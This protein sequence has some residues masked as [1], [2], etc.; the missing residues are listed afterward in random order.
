MFFLYL[1]IT[2]FINSITKG[3][4]I[5]VKLNGKKI[6]NKDLETELKKISNS[7][8]EER[9]QYYRNVNKSSVKTGFLVDQL[10][11]AKEELLR[12]SMQNEV[13]IEA[14]TWR[15]I[16]KLLHKS[17]F[18]NDKFNDLDL[19]ERKAKKFSSLDQI[20]IGI[21]NIDYDLIKENALKN[22][23]IKISN[24]SITENSNS[25]ESA[26]NSKNIRIASPLVRTCNSLNATFCLP[27]DLY[28]TNNEKT[29][30][31]KIDFG[32][33][34]GER[35][36]KLGEVIPIS[37]SSQGE[38]YIKISLIEGENQV[39]I[40]WSSFTVFDFNDSKSVSKSASNSFPYPNYIH[41]LSDGSRA[42][43]EYGC[44][45]NYKI[46]K[47]FVFV[48]GLN[49]TPSNECPESNI[50]YG[51]FGW[52]VFRSG[53]DIPCATDP[54]RISFLPDLIEKLKSDGFD[55]I[56]L[57]FK[58]GAGSIESNA[59]NLI[60][61][62]NWVNNQ[63][64]INNSKNKL[65]V[66]G[67]SM[68]GVVSRY[69][70]SKMEQT[71]QN[72]NT[73]LYITMD[74]P[75]NGANI[76]LG[77]QFLLDFFS[78]FDDITDEEPELMVA[79]NKLKKPAP[80]QLLLYHFQG[81]AARTSLTASPY[82]NFPTK[83]YSIGISNGSKNATGQG[84]SP[85]A[86]MV[87]INKHAY[88]AGINVAHIQG[89]PYAIP[90]SGTIFWGKVWIMFQGE[91]EIEIS[92]SNGKPFDTSPGSTRSTNLEI[93]KGSTIYPNHCFIPTISSLALNTE[94]LNYN[95]SSS[96]LMANYPFIRDNNKTLCPFDKIY[97]NESGLNEDHVE[98]TFNNVT[99][100]ADKTSPN[101][102]MLQRTNITGRY[103]A[104]NT[105][106]L[107]ENIYTGNYSP[108]TGTVQA[109]TGSNT[110]LIAGQSI[111]FKPGFTAQQGTILSAS[112]G[113]FCPDY[114]IPSQKSIVASKYIPS[115]DPSEFI[116]DVITDENLKKDMVE[117][118][119]LY[120][121]PNQGTLFITINKSEFKNYQIQIFNSVGNIV[122][123]K[124]S[125]L[126]HD[127]IN[128]SKNAPGIYIVQIIF[129]D[130]STT[131][132]KIILE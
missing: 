45:N 60:E 118:V 80:K 90:Y 57:D 75:H 28:I 12:I 58:D 111:S 29:I 17:R 126:S 128:L 113:N 72:H 53:Q 44:N 2:C 123:K 47:P 120:P 78:G 100:I 9:N 115:N 97:L 127:V 116:Y 31:I 103:E 85:G 21:I 64:S 131:S 20:P 24:N 38:K 98:T 48:E 77:D 59:E 50:R 124:N 27:K 130:E 89:E 37:Y 5:S 36:V 46:M 62:I 84:Y 13:N 82:Y 15:N 26:F 88:R 56:M 8:K 109:L 108:N 19:V 61:L 101:D 43:I 52:D 68:G 119:N 34:F 14:S 99:W 33:G 132:K 76:P 79:L 129:D 32:D 30:S 54:L 73:R 70:L 40:S 102:L 55:I 122:Y 35:E 4:D 93:G 91:T 106:T 42:Y 23:L 112:V 87:D 25:K 69:A 94:D 104:R 95:L 22:N 71:N 110:Q 67:A 81:S 65:V 63:L 51:T 96:P 16:Y 7:I 3:Q 117:V 1:L 39:K 49:F 86:K 18:Y 92:T 121:N 41:T 11:F 74:S 83:P 66:L 6:N 105:I 107:G 10:I 114:T 125:N